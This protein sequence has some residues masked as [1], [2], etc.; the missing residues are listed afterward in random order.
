MSDETRDRAAFDPRFDPA[1]Q[2]GYDAAADPMVLARSTPHRARSVPGESATAG[3]AE[4][5][6]PV[7]EPRAQLLGITGTPG[8]N[9]TPPDHSGSRPLSPQSP[10]PS[11]ASS[12]ALT[13]TGARDLARNPFVVALAMISA[14]FV[15][16]GVGLLRWAA[17]VLE[18]AGS[19][20]DDSLSYLTLQTVQTIGPQLIV[21]G[22]AVASAILLLFAARWRPRD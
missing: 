13:P 22:L 20:T 7:M 12:P 17:N 1:F 14:V 16:V 5:A 6:D 3:S 9:P 4:G 2:P 21:L 11:S 8:R 19:S 10:P 18:S 15:I